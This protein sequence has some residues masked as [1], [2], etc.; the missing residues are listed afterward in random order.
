M[1]GFWWVYRYARLFL[2]RVLM[3]FLQTLAS[4]LPPLAAL[5]RPSKAAIVSSRCVHFLRFPSDDPARRPGARDM[6]PQRSGCP[7]SVAS[8]LVLSSRAPEEAPKAGRGEE[9][10]ICTGPTSSRLCPILVSF[11]PLRTPADSYYFLTASRP[12]TPPRAT[13]SSQR[14]PCARSR[15]SQSS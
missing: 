13:A 15:G 7:P 3:V 6:K 14:R 1:G 11:P 4:L 8:F 9:T 5:R 2:C 10:F 12:S